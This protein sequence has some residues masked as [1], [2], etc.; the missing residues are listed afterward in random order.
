MAVASGPMPSIFSRII[1][2]EVP[3]R[4]VWDDETCVVMVD[5]RPLHRG[6]CLVIPKQEVDHWVDLDAVV[7]A[8]LMVVAR[9]V[10]RAQQACFPC[11]RVGLMIAGFEVPHTHVHVVPLQSMAN[12]DF[13]NADPSVDAAE[14]DEV[15]RLLRSALTGLGHG[16]NV[17]TA[18]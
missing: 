7:C 8:H 10:G 13:G 11:E 14:L 17:P 1:A 15:A 2:G 12:L 3:G 16:A 5:I 4:L 6:H 18:D 9:E